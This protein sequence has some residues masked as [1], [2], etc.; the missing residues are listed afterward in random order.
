RVVAGAA[1][2]RSALGRKA[3]PA[4]VKALEE[5]NAYLRTR[6]LQNV[7]RVLGRKLDEKE[8]ALTGPPEERR[9]QVQRLLKQFSD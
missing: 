4:L 1:Y 8:F 7:E 9:Q 3:L 6:S 5:P 2:G